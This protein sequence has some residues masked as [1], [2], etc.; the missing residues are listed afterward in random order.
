MNISLPVIAML[1][2]TAFAAQANTADWGTHG[3]IELAAVVTPVGAF[4][5]TF[6]FRLSANAGLLST[7]VSNNLGGLFRIQDSAVSLYREAGAVDVELGRFG[8]SG[9][10][11]N[12]SA[13]FAPLEAGDYYYRI[14]G[15]SIGS[16]GGF[17]A[18]TSAVTAVPEARISLLLMAGL[19]VI[20]FVAL[21]RAR[22][23]PS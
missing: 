21:R 13:S 19:G 9:I 22:R 17:Y 12:T 3:T 14:T 15:Q 4:D 18:I 2:A 5:D 1:G 23:N 8:F 16:I 11:G 20:G 10:T 6:L 7:A